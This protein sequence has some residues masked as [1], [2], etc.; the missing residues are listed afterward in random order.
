MQDITLQDRT[1]N[2]WICQETGVSDIIN[3]I[4]PSIDGQITLPGYLITVGP[5]EQQSGPEEI[6]PE[7]RVVQKQDG[8]TISPD[9]SDPYGSLINK[10][11]LRLVFLQ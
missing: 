8:E 6:G 10:Q 5:S 2:T 9:R 1:R 7:N 3:A 4:K 11:A